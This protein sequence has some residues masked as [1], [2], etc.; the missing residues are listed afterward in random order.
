MPTQPSRRTFLT[1]AGASVGLLATSGAQA[2]ERGGS[3]PARL[4]SET[5]R[6]A[7]PIERLHLATIVGLRG[8]EL[9]VKVEAS[10]RTYTLQPRD[11]GD[12]EH[13]IGDRVVVAEDP[14]GHRSVKPFVT[15]VDAPLPRRLSTVEIGSVIEVGEHSARIGSESVK[16]EIEAIRARSPR[17][18]VHWLLIENVQTGEFRVFGVIDSK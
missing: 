15:T 10:G 7:R 5:P 3:G 6:G 9:E 4:D 8:A 12:W 18:E 14:S 17:A 1:L 16:K 2:L 11:F 13:R